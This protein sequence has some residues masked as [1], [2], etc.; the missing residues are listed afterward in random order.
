MIPT[1]T[2]SAL[3]DAVGDG[4]KSAQPAV[5]PSPLEDNVVALLSVSNRR[6]SSKHLVE[7]TAPLDVEVPTI[8]DAA[9][10]AHAEYTELERTDTE[11]VMC[12]TPNV[13]SSTVRR[14]NGQSS[15]SIN[16]LTGKQTPTRKTKTAVAKTAAKGKNPAVATPTLFAAPPLPPKISTITVPP[17]VPSKT[18]DMWGTLVRND[19]SLDRALDQVGADMRF[20]GQQCTDRHKADIV[21][22]AGIR[23]DMEKSSTT[24]VEDHSRLDARVTRLFTLLNDTRDSIN[25]LV[26]QM[27]SLRDMTDLA[28]RIDKLSTDFASLRDPAL[29]PLPVVPIQSMSGRPA[30]TRIQLAPAAPA[31]PA[32]QSPVPYQSSHGGGR[33]RQNNEYAPFGKHPRYDGLQTEHHCNEVFNPVHGQQA[34]SS[35]QPMGVPSAVIIGPSNLAHDPLAVFSHV[36]ALLPD[37]I[38]YKDQCTSCMQEDDGHIR[39]R[40]KEHDTASRFAA[41]WLQANPLKSSSHTMTVHVADHKMDAIA[42]LFGQG[43]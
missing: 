43:N 33:K 40:F 36:M 13:L 23:A 42:A 10:T 9:S 12:E 14:M 20:I 18:A 21:M 11:P 37:A 22:F 39:V 24:S 32:T 4:N 35:A 31:A 27:A 3:T 16:R 38:Y 19:V 5:F 6:R 17:D 25:S 26:G 15:K 1:T 7:Q 30:A 41:Y 8:T 34:S 29:T 2:A 28:I